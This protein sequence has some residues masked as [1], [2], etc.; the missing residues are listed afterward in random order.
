M[1]Q[2]MTIRNDSKKLKRISNLM[3]TIGHPSRLAI[4]DLLLEKGR[5]PVKA[6][7]ESIG[8]SQSNTSQ[9]LKALEVIEAISSEREG[10]S[11]FYQIE[12][13]G[14]NKLL[15]CVNECANC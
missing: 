11:I 4:V 15:Q 8:I 1:E 7:S 14:L 2:L 5:M 13:Q 10:T 3:K 6:I 12:N 9:H